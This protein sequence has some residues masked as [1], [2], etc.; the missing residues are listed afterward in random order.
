MKI[1]TRIRL[2]SG[3]FFVLAAALSTEA[4]WIALRGQKRVEQVGEELSQLSRVADLELFAQ[5]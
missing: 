3:I 4:A 2:A 1:A 5:R